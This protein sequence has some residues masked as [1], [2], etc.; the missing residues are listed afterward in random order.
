MNAQEFAK[1]LEETSAMYKEFLTLAGRIK[2]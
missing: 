2:K 1:A